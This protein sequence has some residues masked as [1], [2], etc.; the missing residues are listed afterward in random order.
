[1][2]SVAAQIPFG[3]LA[4][5]LE[6]VQK[7]QGSDNKKKLFREFLAKWRESHLELHRGGQTTDSFYPCMR[8]LLPQLERERLAYGIKEHTL[9]KLY[10]D[11][12]GL[13]K[14]SPDAKK[15]LNYKAPTAKQEAGDFASVAYFVLRN[16]CPEKG[17]LTIK[18]VND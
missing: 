6:R 18:D 13:G 10:I 15:L 4:G 7:K 9:A 2:T 5:F 14:D 3:E 12:L 11:I 17:S 1:M 8:L 16:R